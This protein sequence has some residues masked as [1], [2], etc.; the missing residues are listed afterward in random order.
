MRVEKEVWVK[1]TQYVLT[2][3]QCGAVVENAMTCSIC[4]R[5][6]CKECWGN[7]KDRKIGGD[8]LYEYACQF[9]M[10]VPDAKTR[11]ANMEAL[12]IAEEKLCDD[13]YDAREAWG[14]LSRQQGVKQ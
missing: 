5:N 10:S 12:K 2:C 4:D 1:R 6:I 8:I 11:I 9:C 14:A 3:D 13:R 7:N